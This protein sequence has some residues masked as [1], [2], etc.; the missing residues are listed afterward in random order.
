MSARSKKNQLQQEIPGT[1]SILSRENTL[2]NPS[3][4]QD[5]WE[6]EHDPDDQFLL[7]AFNR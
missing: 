1:I 3:L 2:N 6:Y 5:V 4:V 7:D